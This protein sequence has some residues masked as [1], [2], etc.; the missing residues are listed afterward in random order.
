[1]FSVEMYEFFVNSFIMSIWEVIYYYFFLIKHHFLN[2]YLYSLGKPY[3]YSSLRVNTAN[4]GGVV[5]FC[6]ITDHLG[7]PTILKLILLCVNASGRPIIIGSKYSY[8]FH[9]NFGLI[10]TPYNYHNN[11]PFVPR[12]TY[13]VQLSSDYQHP[14]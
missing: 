5:T 9:L 1:M 10:R 8:Y 6:S 4:F 2:Q 11:V 12:I 14:L 7:D 13:T 3:R